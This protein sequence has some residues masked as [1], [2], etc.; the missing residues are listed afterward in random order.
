MWHLKLAAAFGV[1]GFLFTSRPWLN[2]LNTLTPEIG[3]LIKS[4]L[5]FGIVVALQGIDGLIKLSNSQTLGVVLVYT[6]FIMIFNY[7]SKWIEESDSPNVEL[8]T[9]DGV[10]YHRARNLFNLNPEMARLVTFVVVP[11]IMVLVGSAFMRKG[12]NVNLD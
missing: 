7:Q 2:W 5:V 3:L 4:L 9:A 1:I 10:V 8:Q 11:V 12:Q 6:A